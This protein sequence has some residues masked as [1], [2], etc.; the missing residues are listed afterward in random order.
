M[1]SVWPL[2]FCPDFGSDDPP[3]ALDPPDPPQAASSRPEAT[4]TPITPAGLPHRRALPA[5][6][7]WSMVTTL[8]IDAKSSRIPVATP[9]TRSWPPRDPS[10][11]LSGF[12]VGE[13]NG[14]GKPCRLPRIPPRAHGSPCAYRGARSPGTP[15][16]MGSCLPVPANAAPGPAARSPRWCPARVSASTMSAAVNGVTGKNSSPERS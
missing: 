8:H 16:A 4:A 13:R 9:A 11:E 14:N 12:L 7:T 2:N 10:V 3:E 15:G 5:F 6:L 1:V